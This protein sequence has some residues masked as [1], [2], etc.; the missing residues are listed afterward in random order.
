[1]VATVLRIRFRVLGNTL[2]A[3][4]WQLVG[5]ILG[6]VWA[7]AVLFLAVAGLVAVGFAGLEPARLVI[8]AAG[9][10][11]TLVW[12][13]A[14]LFVAGVDTT[15]DPQRF[16]P[17]PLSTRQIM[18]AL[19]AGGLTGV[20][21]LA[22]LLAGVGTLAAWFHWPVALI[23]AIVC[24]P[25]GVL[26][27]VLASQLIT[28]LAAGGGGSRRTRELA[29]IAIFAVLVLAGPIAVGVTQLARLASTATTPFGGIAGVIEGVSWTPIAAAWAAPGDLASGAVAS[30]VLKLAIALATVVALWYLWRWSLVQQIAHPAQRR[31]NR[32]AA[33][34]L[35][36]FGRMPTGGV[37]ATWARS[38]TSWT[39]DPRYLRQLLIVPLF[40]VIVLFYS[41]FELSSPFFAFSATIVA[42]L[43]GVVPYA[44]VSYD[45]SA[46]ATV[47][48]TGIRGRDDRLG[49]LLG[50]AGVGV[51]A[52]V[53]VALV[54]VALSG[55]WDLL[56]A[57]LGSSLGLLL[58][59]YAACAVSSALIVVPVP[60]SGD[61]PFKRVP[62]ASFS[63]FLSFFALWIGTAILA[64]P[65]IV[66]AIFAAV[67][68]DALLGWL[69]LAVGLVLGVV[70]AIVGVAVGGRVFDRNGSVLLQRIRSFKGM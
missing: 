66:L 8:T 53:V 64:A 46:F 9:G 52:I 40:P 16:A 42:F 19:A 21:G 20:P 58:T 34:T 67:T 22:T 35:G 54:T 43:L 33:G 27:C 6:G 45:G 61:N 39:R 23:A 4:P 17:F 31:V 65:E 56:A 12:V 18:V 44:D 68:G 59:G 51:P 48:Q 7:L 30:G 36:W 10:V 26:V 57:V 24:V 14:P 49:R 63:M 50:A 47:L 38:L 69:A 55:R 37:G 32:V 13:L 5:Y 29:S 62:G 70:L 15:L 2:A 60:A 25:L 41:R 11:L 1:M 28:A 3:N